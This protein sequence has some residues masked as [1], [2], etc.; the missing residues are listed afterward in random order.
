MIINL[1]S[2]AVRLQTTARRVA[3]GNG[4]HSV[5][6]E[7]VG[8]TGSVIVDSMKTDFSTPGVSSNLIVDDPIYLGWV[9]NTTVSYPSTIWSISLRKGFVGCIKNLRVNGIS[10]RIATVFEKSNT[11]GISIGCPPPPTENPCTNNPCHNFG[12][13]E[14]FQNTFSC[15]CAETNKEGPT[16]NIEPTV[17][18]LTGERF[19]HILPYTLESEA[20]TIE[21][22]FR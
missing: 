17:V 14:P 15:D 13:C 7:R 8:R 3:D 6:L 9:P 4:W 20:E 10:A 2:G 12:R 18:E 22:R 5:H 1:G 16:C 21:I 11:T 19:L